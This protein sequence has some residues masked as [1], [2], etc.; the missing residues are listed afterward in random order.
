[1]PMISFPFAPRVRRTGGLCA[2]L[3]ALCCATPFATLTAQ[4]S[5]TPPLP[6]TTGV[7]A[8]VAGARAALNALSPLWGI[9]GRDM[10]W[11]LTDGR[12]H[13]SVVRGAD[14]EVITP[15]ALPAGTVIANHAVSWNGRRWAMVRLPLGRDPLLRTA[16]LVHESMH[17]LQPEHLPG[18]TRT[19]AGTGGDFLDGE[20]G[21]TWLFLE[22]R[23][24]GR[25][26]EA[27]GD[28]QR[29]AQRQAVRDAM[30]FRARR[31][32]LAHAIERERLD[33]LD[34]AEGVPEYTGLRLAGMTDSALAARLAGVHTARVSWVRAIGY[35]TG[36]AWGYALDRLAI[37]SW[38]AQVRSGARFPDVAAKALGAAVT[39]T[40]ADAR[41]AA[42]DGVALRASEHAR[43]VAN[44][45]RLDSLRARFVNGAMLRLFPA[46]LQVA[47]DPNGQ[48]P[49][50]DA[51][52]VMTGFRWSANDGSELVAADGA[53]VDPM[54]KWVQV[55]LPADGA[56]L[57]IGVVT[58][59]RTVQGTG[60]SLT[61]AKGWRV[62]RSGDRIEIRPPAP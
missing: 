4:A 10:A 38:R 30:A 5:A 20:D 62:E 53:L 58:E 15:I 13:V 12:A 34:L 32:A 18:A 40:E 44:T 61:L 36:P 51:G 56:T 27:Q 29:D 28:T 41:A 37:P 45:R 47:F 50:G 16:L 2:A 46:A 57:P 31:D 8:A 17:T 7:A 39:A 55:P 52:T 43:A 35:W 54:W 9:D 25:A 14:G 1:M 3:C 19:E 6:D 60:W 22:L 48:S 59:K 11:I 24:L 23:A 26:L 42:Y 33:G 49:L 21:R